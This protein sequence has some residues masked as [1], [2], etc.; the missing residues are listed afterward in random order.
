VALAIDDDGNLTIDVLDDGLGGADPAAGTGLTGL[1]DRVGASN[2]TLV[3]DSPA[4][5]GTAL[6]AVLPLGGTASG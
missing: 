2:G 5:D 4:G 6:R 1:F 3:I